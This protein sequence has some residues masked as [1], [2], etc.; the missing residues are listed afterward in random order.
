MSSSFQTSAEIDRHFGAKTI[1][2]L[3]CGMRFRR[4]SSHLAYKHDTTA[5][6]YK[7]LFNLPWT[8]GLTSAASHSNS[9]WTAKRRVEAR[10]LARQTRFFELA[11]STSRRKSPAYIKQRW[12]KNLGTPTRRALGAA[13][14]ATC[15]FFLKK[16]CLIERSHEFS[17]SIELRLIGAPEN[18][19]EQK[20]DDGS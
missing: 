17:A 8:R 12:I 6:E 14:N 7:T 4:L 18:G 10:K 3:L 11:H 19:A 20:D 2:C 15:E 5:A 13:S 9:G 1:K 16:V